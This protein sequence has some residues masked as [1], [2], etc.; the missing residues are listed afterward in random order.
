MANPSARLSRN[1]AGKYYV[2]GECIG[3]TQCVTLTPDIFAFS[4]EDDMAYVKR[5]PRDEEEEGLARQA[6]EMCPVQS[7]GDDG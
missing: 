3:C 2:D 1:V 6:A 5:Q 7:I 4:D